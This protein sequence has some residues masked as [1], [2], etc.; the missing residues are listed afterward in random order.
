MV[1]N[2][3]G[4]YHFPP[5]V[6]RL[7]LG[8][9][10]RLIRSLGLLGE[11]ERLCRRQRPFNGT[12]LTTA[13][14]ADQAAIAALRDWPRSWRKVLRGMVPEKTQNAAALSLSNSFGNFYRHLFYVLPRNEFGFLQEAFGCRPQ[15]TRYLRFAPPF[16]HTPSLLQQL[17]PVMGRLLSRF[18]KL[19]HR[20]RNV[21]VPGRS[22]PTKRAR[23]N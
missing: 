12:D 15:I 20:A 1:V 19:G 10:L 3:K 7:R 9:L 21:Y 22:A 17:K 14:Q 11:E 2:L 18:P 13:I 4:D 16:R 5:Q 23:T 6:A 8:L